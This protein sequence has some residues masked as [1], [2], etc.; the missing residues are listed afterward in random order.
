MA[1]GRHETLT[2]VRDPP[3]DVPLRAYVAVDALLT[4]L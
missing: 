2:S 3:K 4:G 1:P